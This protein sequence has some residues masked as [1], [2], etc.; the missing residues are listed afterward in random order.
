MK[1]IKVYSTKICPYCVKVKNF[2][3]EKNIPFQDIDLSDSPDELVALKEK[4]GL[5]TVPQV[6]FGEE[7]IGGCDDVL[8]LDASG[9]LEAKLA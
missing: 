5:R 3:T 2:L 9:E 6:F 4:T 8:A 7:F 1:E